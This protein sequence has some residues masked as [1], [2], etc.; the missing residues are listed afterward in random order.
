MTVKLIS[1]LSREVLRL[2]RDFYKKFGAKKLCMAVYGH[3]LFFT[4]SSRLVTAELAPRFF[5]ANG[6]P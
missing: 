4:A 3:D 5:P 2:S 1:L 6:A